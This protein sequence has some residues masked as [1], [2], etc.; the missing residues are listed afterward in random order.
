MPSLQQ[1]Y[2]DAPFAVNADDYYGQEAFEDIQIP[3]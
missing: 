3:Q 2:I 1:N